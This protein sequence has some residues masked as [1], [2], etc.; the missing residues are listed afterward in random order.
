M[1]HFASILSGLVLLSQIMNASAK[2]TIKLDNRAPAKGEDRS[3]DKQ[4]S[5]ALGKTS[6]QIGTTTNPSA[7]VEDL[8]GLGQGTQFV[9]FASSHRGKVSSIL[10]S[11]VQASH[12]GNPA[13]WQL[14]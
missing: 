9:I 8:P 11:G 10:V 2:V 1:R 4:L 12:K 7:W 5:L 13:T 3:M 14:M 6:Q